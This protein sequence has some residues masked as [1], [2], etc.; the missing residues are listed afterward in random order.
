M[1]IEKANIN[2][3]EI[4]TTITKKSK[5]YWGYSDEQIQKWDRN[6]TVTQDYIRENNSFKLI[7]NDLI[8]GY[9]SYIF[10]DV[11][12][13]KLDNLFILPEHIG[14]GFGKYLLLDFLNKM[15]EEK[16][17]RIILDSEPNAESFYSKM[18]FVKIGE[19]E[20]SIKNRFMPIM[21][22]KL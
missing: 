20:T 6:L 14:K 15:K 13:V 5:A 21:E 1:K 9:Y 2:D 4:L 10:K 17:E 16:I 22:M 18:G 8:I 19:F 11:K 12:T 7:E 3:N